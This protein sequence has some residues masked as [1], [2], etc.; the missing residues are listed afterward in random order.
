MKCKNVLKKIKGKIDRGFNSSN[1]LAALLT[2]GIVPM[3]VSAAATENI[4]SAALGVVCDICLYGGVFFLVTS[5]IQLINS[6]KQEDPERQ[7][8]AITGLIVACVCIGIRILLGPILTA[9]G[10]GITI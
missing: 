10:T 8:K 6:L 2:A 9:T 4:I 3:S 1:V 7:H 5:V